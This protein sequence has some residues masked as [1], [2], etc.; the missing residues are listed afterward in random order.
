MS[1]KLTKNVNS[2]EW[3][4]SKWGKISRLLLKKGDLFYPIHYFRF[5]STWKF[6]IDNNK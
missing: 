1:M 4:K 6:S 3:R 5:H 2:K